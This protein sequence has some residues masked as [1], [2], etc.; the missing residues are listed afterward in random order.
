M[1]GHCVNINVLYQSVQCVVVDMLL[2]F[3][4]LI[5]LDTLD[6]LHFLFLLLYLEEPFSVQSIIQLP[7]RDVLGRCV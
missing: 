3:L 1:S 7:Y 5:L 2:Y 4:I 6:T